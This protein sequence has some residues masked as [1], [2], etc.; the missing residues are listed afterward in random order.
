[1]SSNIDHDKEYSPDTVYAAADGTIGEPT[2]VDFKRED[3]D[4]AESEISG[5][6]PQSKQVLN[7]LS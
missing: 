2:S 6:I 3:R 7:A 5:K 4:A 1:M